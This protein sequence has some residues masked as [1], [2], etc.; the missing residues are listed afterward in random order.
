LYPTNTGNSSRDNRN[1][2]KNALLLRNRYG[3]T[4]APITIGD[5]T[6]QPWDEGYQDAVNTA[7]VI[8]SSDEAFDMF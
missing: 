4:G 1:A 8:P 6:Y 3:G 5:K 2:R 7:T